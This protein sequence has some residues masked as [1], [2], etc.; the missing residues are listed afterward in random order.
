MESLTSQLSSLSS[1][2]PTSTVAGLSESLIP[3]ALAAA[4][5]R[6]STCVATVGTQTA[7]SGREGIPLTGS[8]YNQGS[9]P[10]VTD[11]AVPA[12]LPF[13]QP[14]AEEERL[15]E[16]RLV[17]SLHTATISQSS[18]GLPCSSVTS[19]IRMGENEAK[20][21]VQSII[22]PSPVY[23]LD[24]TQLPLIIKKEPCDS[25]HIERRVAYGR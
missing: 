7:L 11:Q 6:P 15:F 23:D 20:S 2:I 8:S 3:Q 17:E 13:I 24:L 14:N 12:V 22:E 21:S 10:R 25:S 19:S 18:K 4:L 16:E 5:H 1:S 9:C